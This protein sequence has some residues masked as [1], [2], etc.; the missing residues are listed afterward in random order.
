MGII[1]RKGDQP[2][3]IT[4]FH[5]SG[6]EK[7]AGDYLANHPKELT[8]YLEA[9]RDVKDALSLGPVLISA[10]AAGVHSA[11]CVLNRLLEICGT[12]IQSQLAAYYFKTHK[13]LPLQDVKRIQEF[14]ELCLECNFEAD[15]K[16]RFVTMLEKLFP[17]G[18][19]FCFGIKP[20]AAVAL[21]YYIEHSKSS[22]HYLGL[23]P[24][25]HPSDPQIH[26]GP[27]REIHAAALKRMKKIP[28]EKLL[29]ISNDYIEK[30]KEDLHKDIQKLP[31]AELVAYIDSIQECEGLPSVSDT[32]IAPIINS[33]EHTKIEKLSMDHF[34]LGDNFDSF[35]DSINAGHLESVKELYIPSI[36]TDGYQMTQLAEEMDKLPRVEILG[37][38]NNPI[39]HGKTLNILAEKLSSCKALKNSKPLTA[40]HISNF[41]APAEDMKVVAEKLAA[42]LSKVETFFIN[43]NRM[44]D[45]VAEHL[46]R[47]LPETLTNLSISIWDLTRPVHKKLVL[48]LCR[49]VRLQKLRLYKSLYPSDMVKCV[50]TILSSLEDMRELTLTAESNQS[51]V[52]S[53][54]AWQKMASSLKAADHIVGIRLYNVR[55]NENNFKDLIRIGKQKKYK[56]LR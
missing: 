39:E 52:V 46:A 14:I 19:V 31:P 9:M 26:Y 24:T 49:L 29:E 54:E 7:L 15:A 8:T 28:A 20:Y 42:F 51:P 5:K 18:E 2:D 45:D 3:S 35:V 47:N 4:F 32:N 34:K 43:E 12:E 56:H 17:Y 25:A 11:E 22:I 16:E 13:K 23:L 33:F 10:A 55:I 6:Q 50:G 40:L 48:A 21:G 41:H 37:I 30:H 38:H 36:A 53:D 27:C 44:S 1:S